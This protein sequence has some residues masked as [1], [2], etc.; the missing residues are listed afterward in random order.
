[1]KT[2]PILIAPSILS[3]DFARLGEEVRAIDE[4]GADWI[5]LDVMDG[6]FVP[7]ITFGP[8]VVKAIRSTSKK[9]FDVHLMIAPADPYFAAFADAGA[10]IITV[11]AEAGPH[12]DRSL[13]AIRSLGKKAGVSLNPATP[14]SAIEYVLDKLDMI[15]LMTVNPGFGGQS[16]IPAMLDKIRRTRA[17]I[18]DR[19]IHIQVDGGIAPETVGVVAA[20]GADVMVAGSA[21]FKG[22]APGA[23]APNIAAI[24]EGAQS[25]LRSAA[26]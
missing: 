8:P 22:G 20:A 12:L 4:A 14:E 23:Y 19:P 17:L 10:D 3:A 21:V 24:R 9:P 7:N 13:Q 2:R 15:L 11:H 18:G 25:G 16:F 5:H 1:V 6:H 26:A